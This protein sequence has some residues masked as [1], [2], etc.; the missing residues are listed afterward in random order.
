MRGQSFGAGALI[1]VAVIAL[2]AGGL[3]GGVAGAAAPLL[4]NGTG[5]ASASTIATADRSNGVAVNVTIRLTEESAIIQAAE[6]VSP[7]VVTVQTNARPTIFRSAEPVGVGSGIIFDRRGYILTNRH[8]VEGAREIAVVLNDGR[9]FPVTLLGLD[10]LTDL[11][12]LRLPDGDYP[13]VEIGD[14]ANLRPGQLVLAIGNPLGAYQNSVTAGVVSAVNRTI[15]A[16]QTPRQEALNDLIQTDAAINPGNSGGPLVNALGQVIG[17]NTVIAARAQNIGFAI[18]IN[19]AKPI[20]ASAVESNRVIRPWIG[21][22]YLPI[23]QQM[24]A[25]NGLPVDHGVYVVSENALRPAVEPNSPAARAGI[26]S[27]DIITHLNGQRLDNTRSLADV[28]Q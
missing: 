26:R 19:S 10:P 16:D 23:S 18:A 27:G 1:A 22:R 14:S 8:V 17:V 7:G 20:M 2:V 5:R 24:A 25:T 12:I 21:I 4:L 9:R 11:A 3:A 13:A 6:R 28:M 15:E